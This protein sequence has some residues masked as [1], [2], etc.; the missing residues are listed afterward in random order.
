M[1][2]IRTLA[3]A[4][5][6]TGCATPEAPK[7]EPGVWCADS[8]ALAATLKLDFDETPIAAG[9]TT[10]GY[11]FEIYASSK[12]RTFTQVVTHPGSNQSCVVYAG[13]GWKYRGPG[14]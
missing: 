5:L 9:L 1:A 6:L 7:V 2:M 11:I 13:I 3:F 14:I 4:L 12:K 10:A 8:R